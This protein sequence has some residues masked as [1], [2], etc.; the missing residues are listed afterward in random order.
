MLTEYG[1]IP[2]TP[3]PGRFRIC[4][5]MHTNSSCISCGFPLQYRSS[6]STT[7]LETAVVLSFEYFHATVKS[8]SGDGRC[9][10]AFSICRSSVKSRRNQSDNLAHFASDRTQHFN[11]MQQCMDCYET[12][13]RWR[14]HELQKWNAANNSFWSLFQKTQRWLFCPFF[15]GR[16][17]L[18]DRF[19]CRGQSEGVALQKIT[20]KWAPTSFY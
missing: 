5:R 4:R 20:G 3:P 11:Q 8:K 9:W 18:I 16:R 1:R 15:K 19:S 14:L 2:E 17:A 12:I 7:N 6:C 10:S 13:R